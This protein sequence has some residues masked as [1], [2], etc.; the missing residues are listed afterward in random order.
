MVALGQALTGDTIAI[1]VQAMRVVPRTAF[2]FKEAL[3]LVLRRAVVAGA[4]D[5][6]PDAKDLP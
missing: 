2:L 3:G 5:E 4:I 6:R 1:R